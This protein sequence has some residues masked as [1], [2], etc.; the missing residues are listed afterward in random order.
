MWRKSGAVKQGKP[1]SRKGG[2]HCEEYV[3]TLLLPSL[4]S[5]HSTFTF[6]PLIV[7]SFRHSVFWS[8]HSSFHCL[9]L[10]KA[11]LLSYRQ[12]NLDWQLDC[13]SHK[14]LIFFTDFKSTTGAASYICSLMLMVGNHRRNKTE[15]RPGHLLEL[16]FN[17]IINERFPQSILNFF[18][19]FCPHFCPC[20]LCMCFFEV[21]WGFLKYLFQLRTLL[22]AMG[23]LIWV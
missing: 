20:F 3:Q 7:L 4:S 8:S 11:D 22:A 15:F 16:S 14:W 5:L 2:A 23:E 13:L 12:V 17:V 19:H 21:S 1:Q 10:P 6:F 9:F 18:Y